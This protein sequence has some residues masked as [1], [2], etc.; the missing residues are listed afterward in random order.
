MYYT[1]VIPKVEHGG[2]GAVLSEGQQIDAVI[3]EIREDGKINLSMRIPRRARQTALAEEVKQD[4]ATLSDE[5]TSIRSVWIALTKIEHYLL[6]YMQTPVPLKDGSVQFN[7]KGNLIAKIDSEVHF[8]SFK[9]EVKRLFDAEVFSHPQLP[10][11][12]FFDTDISLCSASKRAAFSDESAN[13]YVQLDSD[14]VIEMYID[15]ITEEDRSTFIKRMMNYYPQLRILNDMGSSFCIT[16]EYKTVA[17]RED[18]KTELSYAISN[19]RQGEP[20]TA[21]DGTVKEYPSIDFR[22]ELIFPDDGLD[23]FLFSLNN[24]AL[25]DNEGVRF[26]GLKGQS[27]ITT[28]DE[29]TLTLGILKKIDYP[30]V[31][32]MVNKD[33]IDRVKA[34]VKEDKIKK[35]LP[36]PDDLTG[37]LEKVNR[38]SDSF[39]R[40]TEHPED[41]VNPKLASYL[42]DASKATPLVLCNT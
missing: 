13:M 19:I 3:K 2:I 38:L 39:D 4:L 10:G 41:L 15:Q 29:G 23:R 42:F 12:W 33:N 25:H 5:D 1:Q 37:E 11:Y 6:K 28:D 7:S 9:S 18:L 22:S 20:D 14:P 31:V 26:G 34:L 40:I 8:D 32:F 16:L 35:V 36:D 17:E 30:K 21:E 27:F 24:E